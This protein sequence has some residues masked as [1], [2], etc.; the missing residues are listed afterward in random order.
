VP[1][2]PATAPPEI[3][4]DQIRRA[5]MYRRIGIGLL[6]AV[7]LA[8]AVG[9]FGIRTRTVTAS[10]G[11]Y[12]LTLQY[13]ATDRA[14]QPIHWVLTVHRVGGFAGPVDIGITQSY[15]DLLDMNDVEPQPSS[16]KTQGPFVV[17]TFDEPSGDVLRVSIDAQ[18][19]LNGHFGAPATVALLEGGRSVAELTYRTWVAP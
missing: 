18:I 13:P 12:D 7:V 2:L 5:R 15:L 11:G 10:G 9:L 14:D 17:W 1:D 16:A 3:K 6:T 19:Q 8:G 4:I